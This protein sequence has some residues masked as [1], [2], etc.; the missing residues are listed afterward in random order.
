MHEYD[1]GNRRNMC[2]VFPAT[3]KV[4]PFISLFFAS[5]V[6]HAESVY[7]STYNQAL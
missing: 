1:K 2:S 4:S 3:I 5:N 6:S 7:A